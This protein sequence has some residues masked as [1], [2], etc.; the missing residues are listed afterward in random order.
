[1]SSNNEIPKSLFPIR[2]EY[3]KHLDR[4]MLLFDT[5]KARI[6]TLTEEIALRHT[7]IADLE[8]ILSQMYGDG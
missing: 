8:D 4:E 6:K 2:E 3:K 5:A 1:M 7:E